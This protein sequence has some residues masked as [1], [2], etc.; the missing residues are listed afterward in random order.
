M[1][2]TWSYV[3]RFWHALMTLWMTDGGKFVL[4][5]VFAGVTAKLRGPCRN[6]QQ[7]TVHVSCELIQRRAIYDGQRSIFCKIIFEE[8]DCHNP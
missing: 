1:N 3:G 6:V 7:A 5:H 4:G 8:N 2:M